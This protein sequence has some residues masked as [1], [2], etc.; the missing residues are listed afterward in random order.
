MEAR[1][2]EA[3]QQARA[4]VASLEQQN[5][6]LRADISRLEAEKIAAVRTAEEEAAQ[7][8][9]DVGGRFEAARTQFDERIAEEGEFRNRLLDNIEQWKTAH[10]EVSALAKKKEEE[11]LALTE[12]L[13]AA[14]QR[15][16]SCEAK[17][18]QLFSVGNA[19]LD[20]LA[21]IGVG[22][23]LA[24]REPF[25]G[26]RRVELQNIV[27]DHRDTLLDNRVTNPK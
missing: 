17:N 14:T 11:R 10:A 4:Q 26:A 24:I 18:Q 7:Q 5:A 16:E 22:D 15:E 13:A 19:I 6:A 12:Q 8:V 2:R 23:I 1:L 21:G 9:A 27:Q 3:V 20:Q 25:I